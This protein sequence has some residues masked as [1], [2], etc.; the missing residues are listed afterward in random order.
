MPT[1]ISESE[2]VGDIMAR[3]PTAQ[4]FVLQQWTPASMLQS[5]CNAVHEDRLQD[6]TEQMQ[7]AVVAMLA[8]PPCRESHAQ[9]GHQTSAEYHEQLSAVRQQAA[10]VETHE[11]PLVDESGHMV[12]VR[13]PP[14]RLL[15]AYS[16]WLPKWYKIV[17]NLEEWHKHG[18]PCSGS[19]SKYMTLLVAPGFPSNTPPWE[20][21][22][23]RSTVDAAVENRAATCFNGVE[24]YTQAN[25]SGTPLHEEP[26]TRTHT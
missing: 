13:Y 2:L 10:A 21:A 18:A 15:F 14:K 6:K 23:A 19:V 16:F 3:T 11:L 20:L 4:L 12:N 7:N 24:W 8:S 26:H 9:Q 5:F 1:A 17:A 22:E 25:F